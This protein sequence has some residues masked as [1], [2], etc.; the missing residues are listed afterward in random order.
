[1]AIET[2]DDIVDELLDLLGVYGACGNHCTDEHPC[3]CCSQVSLR[4]RI[5]SAVEIEQMLSARQN[6]KESPS[7][8]KQL[9]K[10]DNT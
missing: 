2:I 9:A 6:N 10:V 1:M 3:R 4:A 5:I 7:T 8:D